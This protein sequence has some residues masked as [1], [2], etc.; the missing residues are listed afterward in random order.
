M[1]GDSGEDEGEGSVSEFESTV[2][3]VVVGDESVDSDSCVDVESRCLWSGS[4]S[5]VSNSCV[6]NGAVFPLNT[7]ERFSYSEP[8]TPTRLPMLSESSPY[9]DM[10]E[11]NWL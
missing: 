6:G 9:T 8:T 2:E 3:I 7:R 10:K 11:G 1:I 5:R 4:V